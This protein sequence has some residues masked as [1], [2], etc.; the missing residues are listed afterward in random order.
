M[1]N[2]IQADKPKLYPKHKDTICKNT[3]ET[4]SFSN[5]DDIKKL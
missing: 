4:F 3:F 1:Q 5:I 2:N